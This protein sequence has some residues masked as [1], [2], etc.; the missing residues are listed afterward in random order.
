MLNFPPHPELFISSTLPRAYYRF[1]YICVITGNLESV[2]LHI[3]FL[4]I[5]LSPFVCFFLSLSLSIYIL[6][7]SF[8]LWMSWGCSL[9]STFSNPR[10]FSFLRDEFRHSTLKVISTI[11]IFQ[12]AR[13]ELQLTSVFSRLLYR[14]ALHTRR[15]AY[16]REYPRPV[17]VPIAYAD[18]HVKMHFRVIN[19]ASR[20]QNMRLLINEEVTN[21]EP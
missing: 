6:S 18:V 8:R 17:P 13:W 14:L 4:Y 21:N 19:V 16:T 1:N 20:C 5:S 2:A 9:T 15:R 7:L 11:T 10:H 12:A 3:Y